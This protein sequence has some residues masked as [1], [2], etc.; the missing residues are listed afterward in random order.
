MR[1]GLSGLRS[2]SS[3]TLGPQGAHRWA[4]E[5]CWAPSENRF[6]QG[7]SHSNRAW[8]RTQNFKK[9]LRSF[10]SVCFA[11]FSIF[12]ASSLA[13]KAP[14]R[15]QERTKSPNRTPRRPQE[16]TKSPKSGPKSSPGRPDWPQHRPKW[17]K[18]APRAAL[19]ALN[20]PP[21]P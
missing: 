16:A 9:S 1:N 5:G 14:K 20:G 15:P 21:L 3:T 4:F 18:I 19:I 13:K 11:S 2:V 12:F 17:R 8:G 6:L 7:V 10:V